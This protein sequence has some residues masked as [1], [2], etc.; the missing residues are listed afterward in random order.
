MYASKP[1]PGAF[2]GSVSVVP[3]RQYRFS[4]CKG[5]TNGSRIWISFLFMAFSFICCA[6]SLNSLD[7]SIITDMFLDGNSIRYSDL[8]IFFS[9]SEPK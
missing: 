6:L 7:N 4:S 2:Q 8:S 3:Y 9:F 5:S 1:I